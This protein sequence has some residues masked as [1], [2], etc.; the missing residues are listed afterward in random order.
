MGKILDLGIFQKQTFPIRMPD[1]TLIHI[2]KPT[3]KMTI[4]LLNVADV[5]KDYDDDSIEAYVEALYKAAYDILNYNAEG[6]TFDLEC[7]KSEISLPMLTAI[8]K[9][10]CDFINEIQNQKN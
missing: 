6:T 10:Y 3:Q 5:I 1:G 7:I 2:K 9:G 4:S 8:Y